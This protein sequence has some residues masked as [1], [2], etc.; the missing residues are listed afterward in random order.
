MGG[1]RRSYRCL[2]Y[3]LYSQG[4]PVRDDLPGVDLPETVH[5]LVADEQEWL[6]S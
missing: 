3:I 5:Q 6:R 1:F 4:L 2:S